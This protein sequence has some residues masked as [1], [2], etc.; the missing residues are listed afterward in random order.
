MVQPDFRQERA[1]REASFV[2]LDVDMVTIT[3]RLASD[4]RSNEGPYQS[5]VLDRRGDMA[6]PTRRL[7]R[8]DP[9]GQRGL[10]NHVRLWM[11]K[12]QAPHK[13]T[14]SLSVEGTPGSR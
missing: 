7:Q 4:D 14:M 2:G 13:P 3:I 6:A 11:G 10:A 9:R 8:A 12:L 1:G 5:S